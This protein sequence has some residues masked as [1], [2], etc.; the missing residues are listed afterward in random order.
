MNLSFVVERL[1]CCRSRIHSISIVVVF[2]M[3]IIAG[4]GTLHAQTTTQSPTQTTL[5]GTLHLYIVTNYGDKMQ[6]VDRYRKTGEGSMMAFIL[7]TDTPIDVS[8]YLYKEEIQALKEYS[9]DTKQS[10]FMV[11]PDWDVYE[12]FSDEDFAA[13][14]VHKKIR[15][16][17]TLV[18]PMFGWHNVTPVRMNFSKVELAE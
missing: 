13:E 6:E 7:K 9:G 8:P 14:F 11:V 10:E 1:S 17:G 12:T 16:T 18:F 3:S 2:L 5:S 4:A 15:V